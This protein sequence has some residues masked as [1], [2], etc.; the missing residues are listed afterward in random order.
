M[1]GDL[2]Q[3]E[4]GVNIHQ[5]PVSVVQVALWRKPRVRMCPGTPRA[6]QG[7][8]G[9][10]MQRH[11]WSVSPACTHLVTYSF[12]KHRSAHQRW[13]TFFPQGV[14]LPAPSLP[15]ALSYRSCQRDSCDKRAL[16]PGKRPVLSRDTLL[17]CWWQ[18]GSYIPM[19]VYTHPPRRR[20]P[21]PRPPWPQQLGPRLQ[22]APGTLFSF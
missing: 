8:R 13:P 10:K 21:A 19:G 2:G 16:C 5:L 7:S 4:F 17:K 14:S 11:E 3:Q 1:K 9:C 12:N 18:P 6:Q 22:M 20:L 15:I